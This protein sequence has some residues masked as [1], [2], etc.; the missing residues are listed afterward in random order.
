M[1][2]G[3]V[4]LGS[5]LGES[6]II[7]QSAIDMLNA[8]SQIAVVRRS[9]WF[10]TDPVGGPEGQP[11]FVNGAIRVE[12]SLSAEQLHARLR[13]VESRLGREQRQRWAARRV[14]LDLLL[15]DDLVLRSESLTIPHPRMAFRRFVLEPAA[16][17][18]GE[19]RHPLIGWTVRQ[20][21]D[22]L[23]RSLDYVA[24]TGSPGAGKTELARNA[25]SATGARMIEDP[26]GSS[27]PWI[28]GERDERE[29]AIFRLR[30]VSLARDHWADN[31]AAVSDFWIGQS[32][33]Y[34]LAGTSPG[35]ADRLEER[36]QEI[37]DG[38]VDP[39]LL[40]WLDTTADEAARANSA[41][42]QGES[43]PRGTGRT[44]P[45]RL[46]WRNIVRRYYRGPVLQLDARQPEWALTELTAAIQAMK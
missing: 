31:R 13:E 10:L 11:Q 22:H 38:V 45:D 29:T 41:A 16:E 39:K 1:A 25:A 21:L 26:L 8:F 2:T 15:F 12:T 30:A 40:V 37:R 17:V 44:D 23:N 3:L 20:L 36:W 34:L 43:R 35:D 14:D 7:L 28:G 46:I 4:A 18:A 19:L 27:P 9:R 5:N 6:G 42:D 32:L 24:L 33:A